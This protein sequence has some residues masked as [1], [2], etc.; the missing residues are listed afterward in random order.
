MPSTLAKRDRDARPARGRAEGGRELTPAGGRD[1]GE[2]NPARARE[3]AG[4][5]GRDRRDGRGRDGRERDEGEGDEG[6]GDEGERGGAEGD[7]GE[8][9]EGERGGAEGDEGEGDEG[10]RDE[11]EGDGGEGDGGREGGESPRGLAGLIEAERQPYL[12]FLLAWTFLNVCLNARYPASRFVDPHAFWL[13]PSPDA[14]AIL[15]LFCLL[16]WRGRRVPAAAMGA[17]VGVVLLARALRFGE[18]IASRFFSRTF[19]IVADAGLLGELVRLLWSTTS[20][21][22]FVLGAVGIVA[23]FVALGFA[24]RAALRHAEAYLARPAG[25]AAFLG[26]AA[27]FLAL[28]PL[29]PKP[30]KPTLRLGAFGT[31]ATARLALETDFL[32][33]SLGLRDRRWG[34]LREANARVSALPPGLPGL[35]GADV[36]LFFVESYGHVVVSEPEVRGV[37]AP[38][39]ADFAREL[40]AA[41]YGV[42]SSWLV[43]PTYGGGSWLAHESMAS[44]AR[45]DDQF[46]HSLISRAE[47]KSMAWAFRRAGYRTV[48]AAPGVQRS[49][50]QEGFFNFDKV[51]HNWDFGY[52]GQRFS[53]A[54]MPDQFIVDR[55]HRREIE[56]HSGPLFAQYILL[57]S[58]APFDR[59]PAYIHDWS[60]V[61]DGSI[62]RD[63]TPINYPGLHW[64]NQELA[65]GAYARA[66]R[67]DFQVLSEYLT[68]SLSGR[69]LIIVLGDHQPTPEL[70]GNDPEWTVPIH[71]ISRD[72]ELLAPFER[73]GYGVGMHPAGEP[74]GM[75]TFLFT[76]FEN[77]SARPQ[78]DR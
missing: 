56:G 78:T 75:E 28:S 4:A 39:W 32:L 72:P 74:R 5:D 46:A 7:E 71:V 47:P 62:Y 1:E 77:F 9:D 29:V 43:S 65:R 27:V 57:S 61:G 2:H 30:A 48:L 18:G 40:E 60:T 25:R 59:Q 64:S 41:G 24:T 34:P 10:E 66:L 8:G 55:I 42:R 11:G 35:G 68:K 13:L 45:I 63:L 21:P 51:Y 73:R 69:A 26:T 23:T 16:G 44:G 33:H 19:S 14:T 54:V 12:N 31:S 22:V 15:G 70:T 20:R 52:R 58:H 53:W 50:T 17:L 36:F 49:W 67:Y 76:L 38:A 6:E 3:A 37:V